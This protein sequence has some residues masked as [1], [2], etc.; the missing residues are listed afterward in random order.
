MALQLVQQKPHRKEQGQLHFSYTQLTTYLLCPMKY[1]H[2]YVFGTPY[3]TRSAAVIFGKAMHRAAETFYVNLRE[4]G[5][6][7]PVEQM[8]GVFEQVMDTEVARTEVKI[9]YKEG[10]NL[11]SI[12]STYQTLP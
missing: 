5:E 11:E 2:Q 1:A 7:I 4:Q 9:T 12:R 3:E 8:I 6:V 10:E